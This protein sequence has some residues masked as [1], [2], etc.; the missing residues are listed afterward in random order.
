MFELCFNAFC[1]MG[2]VSAV[3]QEMYV[4]IYIYT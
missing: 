4:Y 3:V 2:F 1:Y